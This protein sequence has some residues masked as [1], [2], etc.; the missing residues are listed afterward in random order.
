MDDPLSAVD[1]NTGEH[2]FTECL[3]GLLKD[4]TRL[5]VTNQ[6]HFLPRCDYIYVLHEGAIVEQGSYHELMQ[7]GKRFVE[8]IRAHSDTLKRKQS[9]A[10]AEQTEATSPIEPQCAWFALSCAERCCRATTSDETKANGLATPAKDTEGTEDG[11]KKDGKLVEDESM[12]VESVSLSTY[13]AHFRKLGGW[14][15]LTMLV[16]VVVVSQV[17]YC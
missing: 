6:L 4:K 9:E 7:S 10:E 5:L 11:T 3:A 14:F 8:L 2:L 16:L 1:A 13:G 12:M 15:F 17:L